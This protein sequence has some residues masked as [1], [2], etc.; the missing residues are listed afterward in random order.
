MAPRITLIGGGRLD[1]FDLDRRVHD[2]N[3]DT[4]SAF[5]RVFTPASG[6]LGAVVDGAER[7]Q[8]FGQFTTAVAPV[9]IV[10]IISLANACFEL[11]TGRSWEAGVKGTWGSGRIEFTASMF[12]IAQD[13]ILTRDPNNA[14]IVVQG[15]GSR[16]GVPRRRCRSCR[17]RR[18]ASRRTPR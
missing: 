7:T 18:C 15:A 16:R 1:R 4:V 11:T 17:C 14:N 10:P 8:L 12:D 2:L 3:L 9:S 5:D 13:D 6:R